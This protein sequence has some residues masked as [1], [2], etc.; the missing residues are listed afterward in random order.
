[1][2]ELPINFSYNND[3]NNK[4]K[5]DTLHLWI[6]KIIMNRKT[7]YVTNGKITQRDKDGR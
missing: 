5:E 4:K 6:G 3:N 2:P 1:M 7:P